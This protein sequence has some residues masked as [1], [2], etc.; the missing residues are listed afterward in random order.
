MSTLSGGACSRLYIVDNINEDIRCDINRFLLRLFGGRGTLEDM[1]ENGQ[2]LVTLN[3]ESQVMLFHAFGVKGYG[4]RLYGS[5]EGGRLEEF[6]PSRVLSDD[7]LQDANVRKEIARKLARYHNVQ[8]P[9]TKKP[10]DQLQVAASFYTQ[11]L[12]SDSESK[13]IFEKACT[14]AEVSPAFLYDMDWRAE[15]KWLKEEG[16]KIKTRYVLCNNDLNK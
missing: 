4:P 10:L 7:D 11:L 9:L 15:L 1:K 13:E 6:V 8:L 16:D 5:F 14:A 3:N 12:E 2:N